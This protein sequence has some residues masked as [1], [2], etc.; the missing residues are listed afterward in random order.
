MGRE[1]G[2]PAGQSRDRQGCNSTM[3]A[4]KSSHQIAAEVVVSW[5]SFPLSRSRSQRVAE[6]KEMPP[7]LYLIC[8]ATSIWNPT[9]RLLPNGPMVRLLPWTRL[10]IHHGNHT[11]RNQKRG[12]GSMSTCY[13]SMADTPWQILQPTWSAHVH[14]NCIQLGSIVPCPT[15]PAR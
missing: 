14:T 3:I 10:I 4:T 7:P 5:F 8:F 6:A 11:Q 9:V 13:Y 12:I 2:I 1:N 15:D